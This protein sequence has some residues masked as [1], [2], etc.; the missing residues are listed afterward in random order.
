MFNQC[1]YAFEFQKDQTISEKLERF[2]VECAPIKE[3][4]SCLCMV[5]ST[6][7]EHYMILNLQRTLATLGND[8]EEKVTKLKKSMLNQRELNYN[9]V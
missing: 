9:D 1:N 2:F 6:F 3:E 7:L 8:D 5:H 4:Q